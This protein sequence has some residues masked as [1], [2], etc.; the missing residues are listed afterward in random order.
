MVNNHPDSW[1]FLWFIH[2]IAKGDVV[3]VGG[4][5]VGVLLNLV[6]LVLKMIGVYPAV[7]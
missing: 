7:E 2:G 5:L 3:I 4:N 1:L 6:L